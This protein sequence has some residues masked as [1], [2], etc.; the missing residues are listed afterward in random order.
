MLIDDLLE[1]NNKFSIY[2][3]QRDSTT[4]YDGFLQILERAT[5]FEWGD[6][7]AAYR[8]H[9]AAKGFDFRR[10]IHC[11]RPPYDLMWLEAPDPFESRVRIGCLIELGDSNEQ[12][13]NKVFLANQP[14]DA[15][16]I[17]DG[18]YQSPTD[19]ADIMTLPKGK[20]AVVTLITRADNSVIYLPR[21]IYVAMDND[22]TPFTIPVAPVS[23]AE[24]QKTELGAKLNAMKQLAGQRANLV[25][26]GLSLLACKNIVT[27]KQEIDKPLQKARLRRNKRPLRDFYV[28]KVAL[29]GRSQ[30]SAT[31]SKGDGLQR[32]HQVRGHL[33]DYRNGNGLFG[34]YKG[35]FWVPAHVRGKQ[36][37][38]IIAKTYELTTT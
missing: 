34:K 23:R 24:L 1:D 5:V 32:L 20:L 10:D 30:T 3:L 27:E 36:E 2:D 8:S 26:F 11:A 16:K 13:I 17:V 35:V 4:P 21:F 12:E 31:R 15:T 14:R 18:I 29:P 25:W 9:V 28:L 19:A 22:G 7:A 33:S 6:V 38:G 37:N